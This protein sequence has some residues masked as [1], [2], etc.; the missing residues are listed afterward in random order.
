MVFE[1][2]VRCKKTRKAEQS[3]LVKFIIFN[4]NFNIIFI[5]FLL[6]ILYLSHNPYTNL[7]RSL[8]LNRNMI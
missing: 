1:C 8:D 2:V 4:I 3:L 5:I 7:C 6:F